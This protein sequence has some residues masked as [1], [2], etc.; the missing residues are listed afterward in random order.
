MDNRPVIETRCVLIIQCVCPANVSNLIKIKFFSQN[1]N[2]QEKYYNGSLWAPK[3]FSY[4][5]SSKYL[6][7]CPTKEHF[8]QRKGE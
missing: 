5:H 4:Q 6:V 7:L 8:K 3:H 2:T 1:L